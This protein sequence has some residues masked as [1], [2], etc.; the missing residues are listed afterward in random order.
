MAKQLKLSINVAREFRFT[1]EKGK[2]Q[3]FGHYW[4]VEVATPTK[5]PS[6][7]TGK[8]SM[9]KVLRDIFV[10][11]RAWFLKL[12]GLVGFKLVLDEEKQGLLEGG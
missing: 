11:I 12:R 7:V 1:T 4:T 10:A 3:N 5:T 8:G 6:S 2:A 9:S